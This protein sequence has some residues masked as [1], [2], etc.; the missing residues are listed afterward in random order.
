MTSYG[1]LEGYVSGTYGGGWL[2]SLVVESMF[3][4]S[5]NAGLKTDNRVETVTA[6]SDYSPITPTMATSGGRIL[7]TCA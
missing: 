4:V 7:R 1:E 2:R 3:N 6:M 5:A